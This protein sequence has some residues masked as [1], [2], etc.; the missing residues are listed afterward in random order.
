MGF[1]G[2]I[3]AW[4]FVL[5]II[6]CAAGGF[7]D[8]LTVLE[9]I[10]CSVLATLYMI[11][12]IALLIGISMIILLAYE[13]TERA[14]PRIIELYRYSAGWRPPQPFRV[15]DLP[16]ELFELVVDK[17]MEDPSFEDMWRARQTCCR[18]LF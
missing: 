17:Y 11:G 9:T 13:A 12:V 5:P 16:T 7:L 1:I 2:E 8:D 6:P 4:T 3:I 14:K 15:L 10:C 18:Y